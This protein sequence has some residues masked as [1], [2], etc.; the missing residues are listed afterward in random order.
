MDVREYVVRED[1]PRYKLSGTVGDLINHLQ[2]HIH[3]VPPEVQSTLHIEFDLE[4]GYYDS[5]DPTYSIYYM[6]PE[7]PE[8]KRKRL[9]QER[10]DKEQSRAADLRAFNL[11]KA[12]LGK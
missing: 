3:K 12:R 2:Q 8:E 4:R 11:L 7:N 10:R 5:W 6:R 9:E 1:D